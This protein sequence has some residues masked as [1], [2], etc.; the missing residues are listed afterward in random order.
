KAEIAEREAAEEGLICARSEIAR[1][2]RITTVGELAASI[3]HELNQPLGSI[4]TSA[5]T[6]L[7]WLAVP[8]LNIPVKF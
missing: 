1:I 6:C 4:V 3:A 5:D 2:A 7:R 8:T